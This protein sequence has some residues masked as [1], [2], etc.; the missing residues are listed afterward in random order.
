MS[1]SETGTPH[2][3]HLGLFEATGVGVGAIV[4]GGILALAGTAFAQTGAGAWLAFL[5]NG[6]I[7]FITALS[8]AELSTAFPQSGGTY[9]FAKRVLSVGAAFSVG[10]VVK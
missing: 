3:R 4:G 8:F 1:M 9:L 6:G 7:A 5:L 2:Q 10:W